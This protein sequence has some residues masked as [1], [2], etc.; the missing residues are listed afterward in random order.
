MKL[1][2]VK[3]S[4]YIVFDKE[5]NKKSPKVIMWE[6]KSIIMFL[7]KITIQ[8][9]VKKLLWFEILK[10]LCHEHTLLV[11]L[12]DKKKCEKADQNEFR[13]EKMIKES[14]NFM[15]NGKATIIF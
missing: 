4:I 3:S 12:P 14:E 15:W 5:N 10:I 11:I 13:V 9:D 8:I 1:V 7:W 2:Y 6:Y